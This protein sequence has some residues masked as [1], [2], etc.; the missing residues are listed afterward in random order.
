M[1]GE[2]GR[3]LEV[4][5]RR[6]ATPREVAREIYH[7]PQLGQTRKVAQYLLRLTQAQYVH[8][9]PVDRG[10]GGGTFVY[11]YRG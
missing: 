10:R 11:A 1:R 6:P 9:T 7:E 3:V 5:R 2:M 4:V 8:R